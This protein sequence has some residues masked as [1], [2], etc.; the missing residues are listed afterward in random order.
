M[1]TPWPQSEKM[2][3]K[4]EECSRYLR[5]LPLQPQPM[6]DGFCDAPMS[7]K[8][9]SSSSIA[10]DRPLWCSLHFDRKK[11]ACLL[12]AVEA[13]MWTGREGPICRGQDVVQAPATHCGFRT[14]ALAV[15]QSYNTISRT[16]PTNIELILLFLTKNVRTPR[17]S[18]AAAAAPSAVPRQK[19]VC[20]RYPPSCCRCVHYIST[21]T[22]HGAW[23]RRDAAETKIVRAGRDGR[24]RE[25]R[26]RAPLLLIEI[27]AMRMTT[28]AAA[29]G[30][31]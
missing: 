30:H 13:P 23:S 25:G 16:T 10:L 21:A 15:I 17:H 5:N 3:Y 28:A 20:K 8:K 19:E 24:G 2:L 4:V 1:E 11:T 22:E 9:P 14:A 12:T 6:K 18:A 29:A 7:D 27:S 26:E 31:F